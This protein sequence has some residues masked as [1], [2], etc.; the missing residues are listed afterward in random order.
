M[1]NVQCPKTVKISK[2]NVRATK[3]S[4]GKKLLAD[5]NISAFCF[6]FSLSVRVKDTPVLSIFR[7]CVLLSLSLSLRIFRA[8]CAV[9]IVV[10]KLLFLRLYG[11]WWRAR[12]VIVINVQPSWNS[13][14][15]MKF[16]SIWGF[17][18]LLDG[19]CSHS[20]F[21]A[22]AHSSFTSSSSS[23]PFIFVV[24]VDEMQTFFAPQW[25]CKARLYRALHQTLVLEIHLNI[26]F[27][28]KS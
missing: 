17:I 11:K 3:K 2:L 26:Y 9:L 28:G 19:K 22:L 27:S 24:V 13:C 21:H 10:D 8:G 15:S 23:V 25:S 5:D 18:T 12:D 16:L 14:S 4:G 6:S 1:K 7:H 20:F